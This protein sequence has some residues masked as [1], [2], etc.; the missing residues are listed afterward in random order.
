M[1]MQT[2]NFITIDIIM[3]TNPLRRN[4]ISASIAFTE[5]QKL[6]KYVKC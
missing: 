1:K 3:T 6:N 5:V 4:H 2:V